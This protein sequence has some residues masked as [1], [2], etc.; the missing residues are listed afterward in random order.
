MHQSKSQ[1]QQTESPLIR[2]YRIYQWNERTIMSIFTPIIQ[3]SS[4]MHGGSPG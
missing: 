1:A 2:T 4:A 3:A